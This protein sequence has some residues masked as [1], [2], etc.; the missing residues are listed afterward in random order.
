MRPGARSL[1]NDDVEFEIF[2]GGIEDFLD[3]RLKPVDLIDKE[4][5]A[6]IEI[7]S[8]QEFSGTAG[9]VTGLVKTPASKSS[10]QKTSMRSKSPITTIAQ[11]R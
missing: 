3:V 4:N 5:V 7:R 10:F 11:W 1:P 9:G 8:R 6:I 2:H